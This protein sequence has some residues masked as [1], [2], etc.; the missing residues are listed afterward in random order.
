LFRETVSVKERATGSSRQ[1]AIISAVLGGIG[2]SLAFLC[3]FLY[4]DAAVMH[5]FGLY[6]FSS[7]ILTT[8]II[9]RAI[10]VE[11]R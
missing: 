9:A 5:A 3:A 10:A 1:M 7:V 8:G 4:Y 2:G 6:L 11:H